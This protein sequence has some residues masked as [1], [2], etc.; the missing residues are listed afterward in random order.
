MTLLSRIKGFEVEVPT[1]RPRT[2]AEVE[3]Y[4]VTDIGLLYTSHREQRASR[5][6]L[7]TML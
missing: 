6:E 2:K 5:I 4:V 1:R 3:G 7:C